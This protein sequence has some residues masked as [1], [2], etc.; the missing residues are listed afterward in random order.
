MTSQDRPEQRIEKLESA[1]AHLQ[2]DFEQLNQVLL[3]L[4][5]DLRIIGQRLTRFDHRLSQ[6][7]D[8]PEERSPED[9]RPPHY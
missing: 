6:L 2:H 9:E 7:S 3:A 1:V 8:L 4:Q 5:G